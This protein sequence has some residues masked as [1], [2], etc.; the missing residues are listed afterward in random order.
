MYRGYHSVQG[1]DLGMQLIQMLR[2][3]IVLDV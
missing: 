2:M 1:V 3:S